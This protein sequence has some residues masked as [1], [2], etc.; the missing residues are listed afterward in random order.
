MPLAMAGAYRPAAGIPLALL[1]GVG[2]LWLA[3][4]APD[5]RPPV[6][7]RADVLAAFG[8]V[9]VAVVSSVVNA[10]YSAQHVV[11]DRDPGIYLWF[12]RWISDHGSLFLDNP[13]R[14][15]PTVQHGV[16]A[17]CPVT[18]RGAPGDRLYVQFL[19]GLPITLGAGGWLGGASAITKVN[20]V[21][22]GLSLL[23]FYALGTR[24]LRP[25]FA[26][27]ATA[28]LAVS[29]PQVYFTRD[30]YSEI[31]AQLLL[32]GGLWLLW[33]A[34]SRR[35][36]RVAGVAGLALGLTCGVRIDSFLYAIPLV[37]YAFGEL[38]FGDRAL[39]RPMLALMGGGV[40]GG[41]L[42][43]IDLHVF[44]RGYLH[45]Q[46][47]EVRPLELAIVATAAAG[48]VVYLLRDRIASLARRVRT[49]AAVVLPAAIVLLGLYA[50]LIR[51]HVQHL[52]GD[53]DEELA[54]LQ[55]MNGVA[56][57][58]R[59]TYGEDGLRWIGWYLGPVGV[60][61]GIAGLALAVREIVLGR[62]AVLVPLVGIVSVAGA[63]YIANAHI[64]PDQ[65]WAMRRYVPAVIPGLI[66]LAVWAAQR[67]PWRPAAAAVTAAIVVLP[68]VHLGPVVNVHEQAGGIAAMNRICDALPADAAVW[69]IPGPDE[70]RLIQPV[71]AFCRVPVG[72][73]PPHARA[74]VMAQAK[75]TAAAHGRRLVLIS[76]RPGP[77]ARAAGLDAPPRAVATYRY[78][79]LEQ[80]LVRRPV[81]RLPQ[82]V[83]YYVAAP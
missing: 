48:V 16:L 56:V 60:A 30:A 29:F 37:A 44:S 67:V 40:V 68:A 58:P 41:A 43:V 12:G 73:S 64:F 45:L 52:T 66:L 50:W 9:A 26:L 65:I 38:A 14:F 80:T 24:L 15:F 4:P 62:R 33:E 39:R 76:T 63:V 61:A 57:E 53:V 19:H 36:A 72:Q 10:R 18:C 17:Q 81:H 27:A 23:A 28:A 2:L 49:P 8:A 22:G 82:R 11:A 21:L 75:R 51:P 70:T 25:V 35:S 13:K 74:D 3:R 7:A 47:T 78:D 54:H 34:R 1:A 6:A 71:H 42:G 55:R 46:H 77:L 83:D 79:R 20:A 69:T 32:F 59:R 31:L 5:R